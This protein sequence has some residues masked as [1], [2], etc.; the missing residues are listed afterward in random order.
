[1]LA[2]VLDYSLVILLC[3]NKPASETSDVAS[4]SS[5]SMASFYTNFLL[6]WEGVVIVIVSLHRVNN[7]AQCGGSA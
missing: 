7:Y 3:I 4:L 6:G 2:L 5:L 1:M